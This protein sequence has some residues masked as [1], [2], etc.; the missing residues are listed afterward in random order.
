M[1]DEDEAGECALTQESYAASLDTKRGMPIVWQLCNSCDSPI[2]VTLE[3]KRWQPLPGPWLQECVA[4]RVDEAREIMSRREPAKR[5]GHIIC[6][7]QDR[8]VESGE[9]SSEY[10]VTVQ[11]NGKNPRTFNTPKIDVGDH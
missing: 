3:L 11:V 8:D 6:G 5:S 10:S 7:V 2:N 4:D 1:F 9:P